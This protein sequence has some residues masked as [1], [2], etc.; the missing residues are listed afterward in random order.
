MLPILQWWWWRCNSNIRQVTHDENDPPT[1]HPPQPKEARN[2]ELVTDMCH[3]DFDSSIKVQSIYDN[4]ALFER[5]KGATRVVLYGA[6]TQGSPPWV[7][8]HW[9]NHLHHFHSEWL[10]AICF[11][12]TATTN[13]RT[14]QDIPKM[15]K[16]IPRRIPRVIREDLGKVSITKRLNMIAKIPLPTT[17]QPQPAWHITNV[18]C[19]DATIDSIHHEVC[20]NQDCEYSTIKFPFSRS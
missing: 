9:C 13:P 6:L 8:Q 2:K 5:L 17:V 10:F 7:R 4:E 3:N 11:T 19:K 1:L 20:C 16:F 14:I 12:T 15:T 18:E